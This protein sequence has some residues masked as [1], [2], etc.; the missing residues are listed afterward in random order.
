ML[1]DGRRI[2]SGNRFG[3]A[4]VSALPE[5]AIKTIETVTGG[6][7]AAYGTD[8]VAGVVNFILDKEFTGFKGHAQG[9][10]TSRSD[11]RNYEIGGT[12]GKDLFGG[13]GHVLLSADWFEQDP[14]ISLRAEK[15]RPWFR[16][17][18]WVTN[19]AAAQA[20]QPGLLTRDF[21]S[22]TNMSTTGLINQPGSALNKLEFFNNNGTIVTRPLA[23]SGVGQ[24]E[25]GCNCQAESGPRSDVGIRRRQRDPQRERPQQQFLRSARTT[26][27]TIS[28]ATCSTSAAR[29]M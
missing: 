18:A 15:D 29:R 3:V 4:N 17:R 27:P 13:R 20:G 1:L 2:P 23:F 21:V 22:Q 5:G 24:L 8:A 7:S 25:G 9:G 11:G 6:A 28:K 14:I 19:P 26:S 12:Y 16:Q 10:D